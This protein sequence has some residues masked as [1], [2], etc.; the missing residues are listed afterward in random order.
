MFMSFLGLNCATPAEKRNSTDPNQLWSNPCVLLLPPIFLQLIPCLVHWFQKLSTQKQEQKT[1]VIARFFYIIL[2][3]FDYWN[4]F[5][6]F[7][8][9]RCLHGFVTSPPCHLSLLWHKKKKKILVKIFCSFL[10]WA[11]LWLLKLNEEDTIW[12]HIAS[13]EIKLFSLQERNTRIKQRRRTGR[14]EKEEFQRRRSKILFYNSWHGRFTLFQRQKHTKTL[15]TDTLISREIFMISCFGCS[16]EIMFVMR[17]WEIKTIIENKKLSLFLIFHW[18]KAVTVI[19]EPKFLHHL[20]TTGNCVYFR[21]FLFLPLCLF[22]LFFLFQYLCFRFFHFFVVFYLC[23]MFTNFA[24]IPSRRKAKSSSSV[25]CV[26][27][28]VKLYWTMMALSCLTIL[29]LF[30]I[31]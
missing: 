21:L 2:S 31:Q 25:L 23:F 19:S 29:S 17:E 10:S 22:Y 14:H 24:R 11:T 12:Q 26:T 28:T 5:F 27:M 15:H 7:F 4:L 20:S 18:R 1:V 6:S 30:T 9:L 13:T 8:L 3:I 16:E